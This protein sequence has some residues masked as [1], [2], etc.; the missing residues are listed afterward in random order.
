MTRILHQLQNRKMKYSGIYK[1]QSIIKPERVYVGS[2]ISIERRRRS[3]YLSLKLG[4]HRNSKLQNHFNKYGE[5]DL[6]F[7]VI[8][9]CPKEQLLTREQDFIDM[10]N[11]WF[12]IYKVAGSPLGTKASKETRKLQSIAHIGKPGYWLNRELYK[13]AKQK[14]SKAKEG[15][16]QSEETIAKRVAKNTGKKRTEETK[17]K[18]RGKI[19]WNKGIPFTEEVKMKLRGRTPWNKKQ[20]LRNI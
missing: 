9:E 8:L 6:Q 10:L 5:D 2:A 13:E 19:P 7:S 20:Q 16:P 4:N 15:K 11:P 12:N 1:I 14:M 17:E 18:I 3:H